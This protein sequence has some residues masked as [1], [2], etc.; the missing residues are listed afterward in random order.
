M[1]MT[2]GGVALGEFFSNKIFLSALLAV[3]LAQIFKFINKLVMT[4]NFDITK[5]WETGGM[6]S[7]HSALASSLA[8]ATVLS[9]GVTTVSVVTLFLCLV[10]IRDS[11]GL[12]QE[13]G[14]HAKAINIIVREIRVKKKLDIKKLSEVVG[15]NF[16]EVVFGIV[17][18]C[19]V[20]FFVF[21]ADFS[22]YTPFGLMVIMTLYYALPGL[23]AN[24]MPIFVKNK[25]K[26]LAVP[27][28]FGAKFNGRRVFGD[29]KTLRGFIFGIIGGLV[30]GFLQFLLS[31]VE[32]FNTISYVDYTLFTSL[33]IG[34]VFGFAALMGDAVESFIKRQ[35][36]IKPGKPFIP[37]DQM[38]YVVAIAIFSYIFKPLDPAMFLILIFMGILLSFLTTKIGYLCK[39]RKEKW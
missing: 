32:F 3:F 25:F 7:S 36:G 2:I 21:Y 37:F 33:S 17:V 28:D 30:V 39:I 15:H 8:L 20:T 5:L 11:F 6:P 35:I 23:V 31:D 4:K 34:V 26:S 24:M 12:R 14:K 38:D 29:H 1:D 13:T 19:L 16:L 18:G 27:V 9:E 10:I 22:S